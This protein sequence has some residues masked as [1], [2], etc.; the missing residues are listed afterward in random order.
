MVSADQTNTTY[1]QDLSKPHIVVLTKVAGVR[2]RNVSKINVAHTTHTILV[3]FY[4]KLS[5]SVKQLRHTKLDTQRNNHLNRPTSRTNTGLKS[6]TYA[7]G[8]M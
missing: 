1:K 8:M 5:N 7:A 6:D 2:L 3:L 4:K